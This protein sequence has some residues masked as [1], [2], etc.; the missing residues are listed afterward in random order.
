MPMYSTRVVGRPCVVSS[1]SFIMAI[2][3][4][5]RV[6]IVQS[7]APQTDTGHLAASVLCLKH[8]QS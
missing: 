5:A 8:D 1:Y 7:S 3:E 2:G 4:N 6:V